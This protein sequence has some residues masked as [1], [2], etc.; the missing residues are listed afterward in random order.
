MQRSGEGTVMICVDVAS[1]L[2]SRFEG[3]WLLD[4]QGQPA[5]TLQG[6]VTR[7]QAQLRDRRATARAIQALSEAGVLASWQV[8]DI[9]T[10]DARVHRY[11]DLS[12]LQNLTAE[13]HAGLARQGA[14]ALAYAQVYAMANMRKLRR[15]AQARASAGGDVSGYLKDDDAL[16]FGDDAV[17]DF[18]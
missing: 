16:D 4:D 1:D 18:S 5:G 8:D 9:E 7:L 15:M 10:L 13:A 11:V 12:A 3:E 2:L 17:L 14:L 6:H